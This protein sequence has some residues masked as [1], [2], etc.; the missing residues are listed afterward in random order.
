MRIIL[1]ELRFGN[2]ILDIC[3]LI[4]LIDLKSTST[5]PLYVK[6]TNPEEVLNTVVQ[7]INK[8]T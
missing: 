6:K 2:I 1:I 5:K 8:G 4:L 3:T 7:G